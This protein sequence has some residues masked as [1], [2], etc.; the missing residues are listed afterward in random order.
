M[1]GKSTIMSTEWDVDNIDYD[2]EPG[3]GENADVLST[4]EKDH[5]EHGD[6]SDGP[7]LVGDSDSTTK[8]HNMYTPRSDFHDLSLKAEILNAIDDCG[9]EHPSEIQRTC[10]P[11][12]IMGKDIIC[13]ASSGLGKTAVFVLSTLQQAEPVAG[14]CW[15]LVLCHTCELA[16][17]IHTEYKR[18]SK[19][20]PDI[21]IAVFFG[22]TPFHK[23]ADLLQDKNTHPHIIVSTPGR[24]K[25]LMRW[26][27]LR[28]DG[29]RTLVL[30]ECDQMIG[31][32]DI[33]RDVQDIFRCTPQDRQ[34]MVFS[35]T[36]SD[37]IKQ[38]CKAEMREP[39]EFY[40]EGTI[41][42][43]LRQDY[44]LLSEREKIN[45]LYDLLERVPFRQAIIFVRSAG[46]STWVN[47]YLQNCGFYSIE[48][49]SGISQDDRIHCYNQLKNSD[50]VKICVA[51]DVFSR[52]IDLEGIDLVINYDIPANAASYLH[53][54]GRAGRSTRATGKYLRLGAISPLAISFVTDY[55]L[56]T[57]KSLVQPQ[58]LHRRG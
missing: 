46:R 42:K 8:Q 44:I 1:Q 16:L 24:L 3:A 34:F 13:Q 52:G 19:Y 10:I 33:Y 37:E 56:V 40:I 30:D 53:R 45:K 29:L 2:D 39:T 54:V 41:S 58:A 12:A 25:A 5:E 32:P 17:Q 48:I 51:T 47:R 55:E 7:T 35:A 36:L 57:F 27:D 18:F 49:H 11:E 4:P 43:T 21:N 23:D 20:M 31:Q 14:V 9:F 22:G 26:G 50:V 15:A 6:Y 38:I 28:L